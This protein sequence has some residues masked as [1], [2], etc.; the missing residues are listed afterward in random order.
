MSTLILRAAVFLPLY[1][2]FDYLAPE[3]MTP[4]ELSRLCQPGVRLKLPWGKREIIGILLET[5]AHSP[6]KK[7]QLKHAMA[8]LDEAPLFGENLLKLIRFS[9]EYYHHP[10]GEVFEAALPAL[11]RQG[12]SAHYRKEFT[13]PFEEIPEMPPVLNQAQS[14]AVEIILKNSTSFLA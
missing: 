12:K 5:A 8:I 9:S 14:D 1:Q 7:T 6:I 13:E 10:I 4:S 2:Q 11:L 3:N